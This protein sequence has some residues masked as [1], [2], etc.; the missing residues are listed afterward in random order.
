MMALKE[1]SGRAALRMCP[2]SRDLKTSRRPPGRRCVEKAPGI[3]GRFAL[4][5]TDTPDLLVPYLAFRT[6]PSMSSVPKTPLSPASPVRN[7]TN[8]ISSALKQEVPFPLS[9]HTTCSSPAQHGPQACCW[10]LQA[11]CPHRLEPHTEPG[12]CAKEKEATG[13]TSECLVWAL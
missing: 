2:W 12:V 5:I 10:I 3:M 6:L 8:L 7:S 1:K 11:P 9:S 4:R 13:Y